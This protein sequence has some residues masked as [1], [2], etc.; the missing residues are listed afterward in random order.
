MIDSKQPPGRVCLY[1]SSERGMQGWIGAAALL[2]FLAVVCPRGAA[3]DWVALKDGTII[4][5]EIAKEEDLAVFLKFENGTIK[6]GREHIALLAK[7]TP[8]EFIPQTEEDKELAEKGKVRFEG[9]WMS[10]SKR[11]LTVKRRYEQIK[12]MIEELEKHKNWHHAYEIET[13]TAIIRSNAPKETVDFYVERWEAFSQYFIKEWK[14]RLRT[15]TKRKKALICIYKSDK[16]YQKFADPPP[17][18]RGFFQPISEEL[19]TYHDRTDVDESLEVLFH[20]GTHL[21][22]HYIEPS[23]RYPTWMSEGMAEYISACTY[24][25]KKFTPGGL[26]EDRLIP[27]VQT[28][29]SGNLMSVE[30]MINLPQLSFVERGGYPPAWSFCH[31]LM[32]N[33]R[34]AKRFMDFYLGVARGKAK[35]AKDGGWQVVEPKELRDCF[36]KFFKKDIYDIQE[37][38]HKHIKGLTENLDGKAYFF[39]GFIRLQSGDLEGSRKDLRKAIEM[40]A[41]LPKCYYFLGMASARC[42]DVQGALNALHTAIEMDPLNS[43]FYFGLGVV[44]TNYVPGSREKGKAYLDLALE[45]DPDNMSLKKRYNYFFSGGDGLQEEPVDDDE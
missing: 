45:L 32:E 38:W 29:D 41:D 18:A 13:K 1:I 36:K 25:G 4:E 37:D 9:A 16:D 28:L 26:Q 14:L 21:L 24:D 27:L 20:E 22:Q 34:Y 5:C 33:K 6:V 15:G 19:H 42:N 31:Y 30:E 23:F 40:G 8:A 12:E 10:K 44:N 43:S 3:Q 39:K 2:L 7:E 17:N 35:L 11:D